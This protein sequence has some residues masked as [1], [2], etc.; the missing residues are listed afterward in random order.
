VFSD[1]WRRSLLVDREVV[2]ATDPYRE[3]LRCFEQAPG[4][5]LERMSHADLQT[6]LVELLMKQDQMSMAA[7][8][9]SRVPFLDHELVEHVVRTPV[10]FKIRGL[11]TKAVLREAL[12]DR[13]PPEILR[14]RKLGFPVPFGRWARERFAPVIRNTILGPRALARGIF[15]RQPLERLVAEHEAGVANHADRLWLL[16]NLEIWQRIFLD[17]EDPATVGST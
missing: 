13:I 15:A 17:G 16:V 2:Q 10:E 1:A 11:T 9:E 5:T 7:S 8:I 12:R 4:S 14:R 6:Y 3:Q